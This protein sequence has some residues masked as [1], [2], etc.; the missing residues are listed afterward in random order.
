M[1]NT[2]EYKNY[3]GSVEFSEADGC[4][5]GKSAIE[6][7]L[8]IA[9]VDREEYKASVVVLQKMFCSKARVRNMVARHPCAREV[10]AGECQVDDRDAKFGEMVQERQ[11]ALVAADGGYDAVA[12]PVERMG[13][14]QAILKH[15][16]PAVFA[17]KTRHAVHAA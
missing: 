2:M 14:P 8:D 1:S 9:P 6:P 7:L 16:V 3:I 15:Q 17:G 5:F 10:W 4:F 12:D 11:F 13:K